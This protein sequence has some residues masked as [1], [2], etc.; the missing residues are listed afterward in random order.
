[1]DRLEN[2]IKACQNQKFYST[3]WPQILWCK[4]GS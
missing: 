2:K 4:M 1:M 3:W